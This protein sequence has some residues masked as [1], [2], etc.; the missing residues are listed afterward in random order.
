MTTYKSRIVRRLLRPQKFA[1]R[2]FTI[3]EK[4]IPVLDFDPLSRPSLLRNSV[5]LFR[6]RF[7]FQRAGCFL[8]RFGDTPVFR[9]CENK[10]KGER[11]RRRDALPYV[12]VT[13]VLPHLL[14][15]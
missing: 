11:E 2:R 15:Q 4:L 9:P 7:L 10:K 12:R 1:W 8:K 6:T 13:I 3:A 14:G 5:I